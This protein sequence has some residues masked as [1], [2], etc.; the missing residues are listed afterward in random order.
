MSA[1]IAI[2]TASVIAVIMIS[3]ATPATIVVITVAPA[4]ARTHEAAIFTAVTSPRRVIAIV[5][6]IP[7]T[8]A[9]GKSTLVIAVLSCLLIASHFVLLSILGLL[10]SGRDCHR[11][12]LVF[13]AFALVIT[14]DAGSL[15]F[16]ELAGSLLTLSL[17]TL[18]PFDLASLGGDITWCLLLLWPESIAVCRG[19]K[20]MRSAFDPSD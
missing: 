14:F 5:I 13:G 2:P 8:A 10:G 19:L 15:F 1:R 12:V 17:L 3:R 20:S 16:A 7:S 6:V 9:S 18:S 4:V 11:L